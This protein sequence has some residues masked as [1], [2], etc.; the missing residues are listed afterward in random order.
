MYP[1]QSFTLMRRLK[2]DTKHY[3]S[4][5][6]F[7]VGKRSISE[8]WIGVGYTEYEK[9]LLPT[10][11]LQTV[12]LKSNQELLRTVKA[13]RGM[14]FALDEKGKSLTSEEFSAELFRSYEIGGS[15]VDFVIGGHDGLPDE[16]RNSLPLLS[17]SKMTWP[18]QMARLLLIE[19]IY[20]SFEIRRGS[21][22]HR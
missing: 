7:I 22:Y 6:I 14:L 1:K 18:H 4:T 9:R 20:R 15:N 12:F 13:C 5:N 3:L 19:Q 8:D 16:L 21:G 10:V 17:L 11:K 2:Y